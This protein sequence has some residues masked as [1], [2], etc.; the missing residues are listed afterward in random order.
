MHGANMMSFCLDIMC[1][2]LTSDGRQIEAY[3]ANMMSF[4]L[5]IDVHGANMMSFCL[6]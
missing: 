5:R 4:C 3:G 6:S 2:D 1:V